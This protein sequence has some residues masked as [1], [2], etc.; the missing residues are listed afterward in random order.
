MYSADIGD[1]GELEDRDPCPDLFIF[2][3]ENS[4]STSAASSGKLSG[5]RNSIAFKPGIGGEALIVKIS[6]KIIKGRDFREKDKDETEEQAYERMRGVYARDIDICLLKITK[7]YNSHQVL[8]L[9]EGY[10]N[11]L[12]Q[13]A[14]HSIEENLTKQIKKAKKLVEQAVE[15][16]RLAEEEKQA[17]AAT[18]PRASLMS[19][20][21]KAKAKKD[22]SEEEQRTKRLADLRGPLD[23]LVAK[24]NTLD[25][26]LEE[27]RLGFIGGKAPQVVARKNTTTA[28]YN[29]K[30]HRLRKRKK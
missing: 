10:G 26:T 20:K 17:A 25:K 7:K 23:A 12:F 14:R 11:A 1:W 6:D 18:S 27:I 2:I 8:E 28:R 13:I 30:Q 16:I 22:L 15:K 21:V 4:K 24:L 5:I 19:P 9:K 29:Q 3:R